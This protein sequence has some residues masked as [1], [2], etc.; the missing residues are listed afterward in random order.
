MQSSSSC[1]LSFEGVLIY[2]SRYSYASTFHAPNV[3]FPPHFDAFLDHFALT[4]TFRVPLSTCLFSLFL[5]FLH[6]KFL[7]TWPYLS[8]LPRGLFGRPQLRSP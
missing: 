7:A 1:Y 4:S 8:P 2:W 5:A 6:R 3:G